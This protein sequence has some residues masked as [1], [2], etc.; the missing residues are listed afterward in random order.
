MSRIDD[1]IAEHCPHGVEFRAL[2]DVGIWYGGG[3]P[4]KSVTEYWDNGTVPWLSPKDMDVQT[5]E[6]T[7]LAV[8]EAA[9]IR[10]PLK[11][12]PAGSVAFVVRSN[13]LRRRLPVALVPFET[14]L[15]QDMRAVVPHEEILPEFL[16]HACRSRADV[17]LGVAGRTDGSMAAINSAALLDYEVPVPPIPVQEEVVRVV[18]QLSRLQSELETELQAELV[19]RRKQFEHYRSAL[20]AF[21]ADSLSLSLS[22]P[23]SG[24]RP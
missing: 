18:D 12:V 5:V 2:R 11:L 13:V 23:P 4:A 24:G 22:A 21:D 10:S 7:G 6:S 16:L 19:A 1:L 17:I 14:T 8:S 15:N 3:T 20:L 9:L